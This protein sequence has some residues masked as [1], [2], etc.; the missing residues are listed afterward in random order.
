MIMKKRKRLS[1]VFAV[2]FAVIFMSN[3]IVNAATVR[4]TD[5]TS[6]SSGCTIVGVSGKYDKPDK[7]ALLKQL[8]DIRKEACNNGYYC[9]DL[10]RNLREGMKDGMVTGYI[11]DHEF[12]MNSK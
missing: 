6:P 7:A 4:N 1:M 11:D 3:S 12:K 8:N 2:I 9:V 5:K 10:K